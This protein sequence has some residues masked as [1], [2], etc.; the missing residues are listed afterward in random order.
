MF[1]LSVT[2]SG[3]SLGVSVVVDL[4]VEYYKW[5]GIITFLHILFDFNTI[6]KKDFKF[7][8]RRNVF[9]RFFI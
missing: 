5:S 7:A 9:S 1:S 8:Y 6:E 4:P 3:L 2:I